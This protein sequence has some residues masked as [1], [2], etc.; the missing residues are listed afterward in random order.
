[1]AIKHI[2]WCPTYHEFVEAAKK[3]RVSLSITGGDYK[4]LFKNALDPSKIVG[5]MKDYDELLLVAM[6]KWESVYNQVRTRAVD[7]VLHDA[8]QEHILKVI[9]EFV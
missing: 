8:P 5:S 4:W 2:D 3:G 1:M 7:L 6:F 9:K